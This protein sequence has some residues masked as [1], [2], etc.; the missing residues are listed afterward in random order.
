LPDH[1]VEYTNGKIVD[2]RNVREAN[3]FGGVV[4][5]GQPDSTITTKDGQVITISWNH[6]VQSRH[7]NQVFQNEDGGDE[8]YEYAMS[9][10][11]ESE[12]IVSDHENE[13]ND[14]DSEFCSEDADVDIDDDDEEEEGIVLYAVRK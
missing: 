3:P 4:P 14:D 7:L 10:S 8:D 5:S 13:S 12:L 1:V 2:Y 6:P 9:T 11:S